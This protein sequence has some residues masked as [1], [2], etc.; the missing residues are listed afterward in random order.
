MTDTDGPR[1][2][3]RAVVVR[4]R[5]RTRP[6]D[7]QPPSTRGTAVRHQLLVVVAL[8]LAACGGA[9]DPAGPVVDG[10]PG[11]S[12]EGSWVLVSATPTIAVPDTARVT[13]EVSPEGDAWRVGGVAACNSYGGTVRTD[14]TTW[15]VADGF[16]VTEMGC[17]GGLM[18]VER[19][20]L[21]ALLA[22]DAWQRTAGDELV[23]SGPDVELRFELL[24]ALDPAALVG[25]TWLLDGLVSG[26][27]PDGAVSSTTPSADEA[28]LRLAEDGTV[29]ASTGCRT[30]TGT[31][32]EPGDEVL[33]DTFGQRDD[34][35]NVGDDGTPTCDEA[36][37]A[38]EDHVLSVL[39]DGFRA[40]VDG[41]RL[42]LTSRDG[43]GLT[44]VTADPDQ[45]RTSAPSEPE[46]ECFAA[47]A[48]SSDGDGA[49]TREAAMEEVATTGAG[50]WDPPPGVTFEDT[51]L[52]YDGEEIGEVEL[53]QFDNGTWA[54]SG[55]EVCY[56][57]G[58][59]PSAR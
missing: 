46:Q 40:E 24:E 4:R 29:E 59:E 6:V 1:P 57:L 26:T 41:R 58:T 11:A 42:H 28:T 54:V 20:Y 39:G 22:V 34:S 38:Q 25:T 10:D 16:A 43:L 30:F 31:W 18:D 3:A 8:L 23:L 19:A 44:W 49:P 9:A 2:T 15:A 51:T 14:G 53:F 12:P 37:L 7:V 52:M 47:M 48:M 5:N 33:L 27:G 56:P 55:I 45:P 32:V 50:W 36:V 35:P 13:L 21:D 17:D